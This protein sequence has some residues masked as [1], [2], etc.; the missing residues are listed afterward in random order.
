[1]KKFVHPTQNQTPL[2]I[3]LQRRHK[4]T[5]NDKSCCN[6]SCSLSPL[7][8][9]LKYVN[10]QISK[11]FLRQK[12]GRFSVLYPLSPWVRGIYFN[13]SNLHIPRNECEINHILSWMLSLFSEQLGRVFCDKRKARGSLITLGINSYHGTNVPSAKEGRDS[14]DLKDLG[15][16][17]TYGEIWVEKVPKC[18]KVIYRCTT[19]WYKSPTKLELM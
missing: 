3:P 9:G 11:E 7:M 14:N 13:Q 15:N 19:F 2:E 10:R 1:M 8:R 18:A 4:F 5:H 17:H 16:Y 6:L 12:R